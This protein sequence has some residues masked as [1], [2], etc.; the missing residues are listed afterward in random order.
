MQKI[1]VLNSVTLRAAHSPVCICCRKD[2]LELPRTWAE[3]KKCSE[4]ITQEYMRY[5]NL[6]G[7]PESFY[8]GRNLF[9]L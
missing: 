2:E 1:Q 4:L 8:S 7:L 6:K 3:G 5:L 9:V